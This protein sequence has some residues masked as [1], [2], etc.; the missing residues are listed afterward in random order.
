MCLRGVGAQGGELRRH[1]CPH[2]DPV[3][4]VRARGPGLVERCCIEVARGQAQ[5][6]R[7]T[8]SGSDRLAGERRFELSRGPLREQGG[9]PHRPVHL[10]MVRMAVPALGVVADDDVGLLLVEHCPDASSDLEP[11]GV[12]EAL[13]MLGVQSGVP[14]AELHEPSHAEGISRCGEFGRPSQGQVAGH[15]RRRESSG[16]IGRDDEHDPLALGSGPCHGAGGEQ[17]LVVRM[18]VHEHQRLAGAQRPGERDVGHWHIV[19]Y[20]RGVRIAHVSDC[21]L[22]R[23]GGIE[24]QVRALALQQASAGDEPMVI[25]ATAGASEAPDEIPVRRIAM[26]LP[27]DLPI[28]PRT[29]ERVAQVL[30]ENPVDVVHVHAGVVSPFAW[31]A[32]RAAHEVGLPCVVT[33][34]SMWGP[35]A[36][37]G[38]A[39]S[40]SLGHWLD[41]GVKLSAVSQ[42]AADRVH[43]ALPSAGRVL[44]LPNGIDPGPWQVEP[45]AGA[46]GELRLV[47]V[48]RLAPRKRTLPMLRMV[49]MVHRSLLGS[50]HLSLTLVGDGPERAVAQRF[51]EREGLSG[52]VRL[53]GRLD[54][55]GIR[56]QFAS[57]DVF[58]QPSVRES[59]GLA[60]LEAR[61]AGLPVIAREQSGTTQFI[62][63]GVSGLIVESDGGMVRAILRLARDPELRARLAQHNRTTPP[64]QTWPTVLADVTAAYRAAGA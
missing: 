42:A 51:I 40:Q 13:R 18:R 7:G 9:G 49:Q 38:Y 44:V 21:Y 54:R 1:V 2:V 41:W 61:C 36:T 26:D 24:T 47:S 48:M 29:R 58:V 11:V 52:V 23:T 4:D 16:T 60:A 6:R 22:P 43:A 64:T 32:V 39:M 28:H 46:P 3:S 35:I 8:D 56:A 63:D 27:F 15:A 19:A 30:R 34:H 14:I 10:E 12:G 50:A 62:S 45:I 17:R 55:D 20:G 33:V 25:T 31:G 59:F 37:P 57:S 53:T 5:G